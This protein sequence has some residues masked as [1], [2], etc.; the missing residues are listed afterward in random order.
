VP[1]AFTEDG[2]RFKIYLN[3]HAPA[4]CHVQRDDKEA[5]VL[6]VEVAVMSS[7][8]FHSRELTRIVKLVEDHQDLLLEMWDTYHESR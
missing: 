1:T 3:D 2:Y 5:R 8:G 7:E 4:H 6:L